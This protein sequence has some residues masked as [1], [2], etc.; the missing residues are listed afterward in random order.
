MGRFAGQHND[1][2][3]RRLGLMLVSFLILVTVGFSAVTD[4]QE[5]HSEKARAMLPFHLI[6]TSVKPGSF[7]L[8]YRALIL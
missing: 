3:Y 1:T 6:S 4:A 2:S 5:G 7:P 8:P